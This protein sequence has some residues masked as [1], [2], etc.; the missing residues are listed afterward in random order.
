MILATNEGQ[1]APQII[2]RADDAC[3]GWHR[4]Y[5]VLLSLTG[6]ALALQRLTAVRDQS[7]EGVIVT[8]VYPHAVRQ[9]RA[10]SAP[11]G[12]PVTTLATRAV[13]QLLSRGHD[14]LVAGTVG[15]L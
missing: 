1:D 14:C 6:I 5:D 15:I 13:V 9:R 10:N 4:G 2:G 7:E 8:A 3:H 11:A 12:T